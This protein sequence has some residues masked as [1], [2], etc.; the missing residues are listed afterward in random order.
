MREAL[1]CVACL[2][3]ASDARVTNVLIEVLVEVRYQA[4]FDLQ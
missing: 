3:L 2:P 1:V 4:C